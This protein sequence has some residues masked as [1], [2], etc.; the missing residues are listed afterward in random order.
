M[1]PNQMVIIRNINRRKFDPIFGPQL[2]KVIEVKGNGATL[3]HIWDGKIVRRHLN[4]IKDASSMECEGNDTCWIEDDVTPNYPQVVTH[5]PNPILP[6][7]PLSYKHPL[8]LQQLK[9]QLV[10]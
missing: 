9:P 10:E 3:L 5:D 2:H 8:P 7:T 1:I 6:T 4:D